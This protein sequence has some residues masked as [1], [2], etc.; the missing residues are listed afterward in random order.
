M[1]LIAELPQVYRIW[2]YVEVVILLLYSALVSIWQIQVL[3]GRSMANPD[4]STDDWHRQASQYGMAFA[5]VMLACPLAIVS[6]VMIL[7]NPHLGF[8][9]LGMVGF[10]LV[11][12]NTATTVTSLRFHRPK[13]TAEWVLVFPFGAVVGLAALMWPVAVTRV[14]GLAGTPL[15]AMP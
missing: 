12:A 4:G 15:G 1:E 13:L 9:L 3:R 5:D 6:L 14:I 2:L 10:W 7:A 11:W 8:Y